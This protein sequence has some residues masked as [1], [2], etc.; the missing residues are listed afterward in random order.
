M[1]I[2]YFK[3]HEFKDSCEI[4]LFLNFLK[5]DASISSKLKSELEETFEKIIPLQMSLNCVSVG[6]NS[7]LVAIFNRKDKNYL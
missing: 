4:T 7:H 2:S 1:I 6:E 3:L 5:N